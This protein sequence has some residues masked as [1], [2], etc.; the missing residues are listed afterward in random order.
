LCDAER[1]QGL[2]EFGCG[3]GSTLKSTRPL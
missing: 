3:H 1:V 2:A